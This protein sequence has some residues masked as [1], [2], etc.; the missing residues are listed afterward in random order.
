MENWLV[1]VIVNALGI[2]IYLLKESPI[3]AAQYGF[4]LILGVYGWWSWRRTMREG[5]A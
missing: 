1:W 5:V 4:F 3:Y 2:H